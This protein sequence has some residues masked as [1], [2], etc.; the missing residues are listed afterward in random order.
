LKQLEQIIAEEKT[1]RILNSISNRPAVFAKFLNGN[2]DNFFT[3]KD[4]PSELLELMAQ[5]THAL[6]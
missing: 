5:I 4:I 2:K 3:N 6:N 1:G